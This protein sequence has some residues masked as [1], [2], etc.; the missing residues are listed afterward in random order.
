MP[1]AEIQA[2]LV[3]MCFAGRPRLYQFDHQGA[4]EEATENLPFVCLGSG[5]SNADP[6][7][8][9]LKGI[10]WEEG[11]LPPIPH[12][13]FAAVWTV[14]QL[15][16]VSP[17]LLGDPVRVYVLRSEGERC[18]AAQ[19]SDAELQEAQQGVDDARR[20]LKEWVRMDREAPELP[21]K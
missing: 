3:A 21:Q 16:K 15:I 20:V 8:A 11:Q 13:I 5:Q 2:T 4:P 7:L 1:V 18:V 10:F 14:Q 19:L 6:F 12:A 17:A 9:F